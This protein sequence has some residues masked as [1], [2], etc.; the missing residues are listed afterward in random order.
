M[1]FRSNRALRFKPPGAK[2]GGKSKRQRD[3]SRSVR[4]IK[5]LTGKLQLDEKQQAALQ[6]FFGDAQETIKAM[7]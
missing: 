3:P 6:G 4:L 5:S 2:G 7:Y 1:L